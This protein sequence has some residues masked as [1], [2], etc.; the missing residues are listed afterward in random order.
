[1][2]K[3]SKLNIKFRK[4]IDLSIIS[5]RSTPPRRESIIKD[6]S[7]IRTNYM[8][9]INMFENA[10]KIKPAHKTS[11]KRKTFMK[12]KVGTINK[13]LKLNDTKGSEKFKIDKIIRKKSNFVLMRTAEINYTN[14]KNMGNIPIPPPY[15]IPKILYDHIYHLE[16]S[17][18]G[19]DDDCEIDISENRNK[20]DLE[21]QISSNFEN[22]NI[23]PK[24]EIYLY[25]NLVISTNTFELKQK[26]FNLNKQPTFA[27][28]T[29]VLNIIS[30]QTNNNSDLIENEM[31][32]NSHKNHQFS[33]FSKDPIQSNLFKISV[34]RTSQIK[35]NSYIIPEK[36]N[37]IKI[38]SENQK[39]IASSKNNNELIISNAVQMQFPEMKC[40]KNQIIKKSKSIIH[41]D[42][43]INYNSSINININTNAPL[44]NNN[45][46]Y[47]SNVEDTLSTL[48]ININKKDKTSYL[49]KYKT[50]SSNSNQK[51]SNYITSVDTKKFSINSNEI[52][53]DNNS[54]SKTSVNQAN[55]RN[56]R[57]LSENFISNTFE[58]IPESPRLQC[59]QEDNY[60]HYVVVH[61]NLKYGNKNIDLARKSQITDPKEI[62]YNK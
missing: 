26:A 35:E 52:S 10:K 21:Y 62:L 4:Q 61:K 25:N 45:S 28:E 18:Q 33:F 36:Q 47:S 40:I 17:F 54:P 11:R 16:N 53:Q 15:I 20:L 7:M 29:A 44:N 49:N 8:N 23:K 19:D 38:I 24:P 2:I 56:D 59:N 6:C 48:R 46:N 22:F 27:I 50:I 13:A 43:K 39:M 14:H 34:E 57:Y 5:K 37:I 60:H 30:N 58:T 31:K 32:S 12:K 9:I 1:M 42:E 41:S 51:A 55:S 3:K